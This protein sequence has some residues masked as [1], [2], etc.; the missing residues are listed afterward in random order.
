MFEARMLGSRSFAGE[1]YG[2]VSV[3]R[4]KLTCTQE[5]KFMLLNLQKVLIMC[6]AFAFP[7]RKQ[8]WLGHLKQ[9]LNQTVHLFVLSH[10]R[11]SY[12]TY[13]YWLSAEYLIKEC[14]SDTQRNTKCLILKLF[15]Q[16]IDYMTYC[17]VQER[18]STYIENTL[19]NILKISIS[20][21]IVDCLQG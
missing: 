2:W 3:L 7:R 11:I 21:L 18:I 14:I 20:M 17:T 4:L 8:W 12:A 6:P 1:K 13:I 19:K 5:W 9:M 10:V 15:N 16:K